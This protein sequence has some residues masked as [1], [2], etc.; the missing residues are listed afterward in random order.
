MANPTIKNRQVD[1]AGSR[2]QSSIDL[3]I[4]NE[5][6]G[7]RKSMEV[8]RALLPLQNGA[9]SWTTNASAAPIALPAAGKNLAIYNNSSTVYSVTVGDSTMTAQ[10]VGAVQS[11]ATA[12]FVGVPCQP[13]SWTYLSTGQWNF[14]ATNNAS[15]QV[16]LIDDPT[17]II[18]QPATNAST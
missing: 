17:F 18:T 6:S 1:G 12:P 9:A 5:R 13:N 16:F 8:G 14:V 7:A 4:Y 3:L 2:D 15:L 11:G 10:A